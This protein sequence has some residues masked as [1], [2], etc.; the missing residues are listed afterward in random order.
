MII[1]VWVLLL[2]ISGLFYPGT[3]AKADEK[4]QIDRYVK[5]NVSPKVSESSEGIPW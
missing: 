2:F 1:K 4:I 5:Y 3:I